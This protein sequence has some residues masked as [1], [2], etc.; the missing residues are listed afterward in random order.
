MNPSPSEIREAIQAAPLY[1][2]EDVAKHYVGLKVKWNLVVQSILKDGE[3]NITVCLSEKERDLTPWVNIKAG[4]DEYPSLK[5]AKRGYKVTVEGHIKK[6]DTDIFLKDTQLYFEDEPARAV[7]KP[8]APVTI[9]HSQVHY[10]NGDNVGRDKVSPIS[11]GGT[12]SLFSKVTNNQTFAIIVGGLILAALVSY[13][14][15]PHLGT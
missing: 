10:G 8:V 13:F 2:Q 9:T 6:A 4:V 5:F 14:G 15:L 12:N 11:G 7:D 1:Q 3:K